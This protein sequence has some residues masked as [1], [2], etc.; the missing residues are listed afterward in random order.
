MKTCPKCPVAALQMR[1]EFSI[2]P[3]S[4]EPYWKY[5]VEITPSGME[6]PED[7]KLVISVYAPFNNRD[8]IEDI[9]HS[10]VDDEKFRRCI[11]VIDANRLGP[12]YA[13][14]SAANHYSL[15]QAIRIVKTLKFTGVITKTIVETV[16][17]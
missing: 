3:A 4:N 10:A 1:A 15:T 8:A 5:L 2:T 16:E 14:T 17:L 6:I 11:R 7:A 12:E 13:K 9:L